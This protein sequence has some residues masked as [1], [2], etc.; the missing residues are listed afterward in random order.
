MCRRWFGLALFPRGLRRL[1]G[2]GSVLGTG[3][4][5]HELMR[6]LQEELKEEERRR[7]GGIGEALRNCIG[8]SELDHLE[9]PEADAAQRRKLDLMAESL[10]SRLP[11]PEDP[12]KAALAPTEEELKKR[13]E[14]EVLKEAVREQYMRQKASNAAEEARLSRAMKRYEVVAERGANSDIPEHMK[15]PGEMNELRQEI[16]N[17][18]HQLAKLEKLLDSKVRGQCT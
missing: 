10:F 18:K 1:S 2:F 16:D 3:T 8:Q 4:V 14:C 5:P 17:L 15:T 13:E 7:Q 12:M 9:S 11:L 6:T